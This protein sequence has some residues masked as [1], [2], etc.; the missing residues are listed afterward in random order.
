MNKRDVK[1]NL[2]NDRESDKGNEG[3]STEKI[4]KSEG[5]GSGNSGTE[6]KLPGRVVGGRM[7]GQ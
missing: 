3:Y 4:Y 7:K 6:I 2:E 5:E 1:I